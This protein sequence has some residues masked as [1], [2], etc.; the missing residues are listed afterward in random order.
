MQKQRDI[1][2]YEYN[3]HPVFLP[4]LAEHGFQFV[5]YDPHVSQLADN[6]EQCIFQRS[7][8]LTGDE[9]VAPFAVYFVVDLFF[10]IA[11]RRFYVG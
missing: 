5:V 2:N 7:V 6:R 10:Q 3:H 9:R 8:V 11:N 1:G 4:H